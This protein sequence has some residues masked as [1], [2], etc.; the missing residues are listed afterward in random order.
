MELTFF[1]GNE[2]CSILQRMFDQTAMYLNFFEVT[3][4]HMKN[5]IW[6]RTNEIYEMF[7]IMS[8]FFVSIVRNSQLDKLNGESAVSKTKYVRKV[9]RKAT[10]I[11]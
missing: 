6:N 3:E 10:N 4:E 9:N 5:C 1:A 11:I 8:D 2:I 7:H